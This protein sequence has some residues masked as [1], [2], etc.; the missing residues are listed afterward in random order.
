MA[1]ALAAKRERWWR[2]EHIRGKCQSN[3]CHA[4]SCHGNSLLQKGPFA[5]VVSLQASDR[6]DS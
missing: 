1:G 4:I 3:W 5:V 2:G 6:V